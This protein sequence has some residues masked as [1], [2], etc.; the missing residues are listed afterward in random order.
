MSIIKTEHAPTH[1]L[2][3][4]DNLVRFSHSQSIFF[5]LFLLLPLS[6][7]CIYA[8][9]REK[10]SPEKDFFV[11]LKRSCLYASEQCMYIRREEE[12][13][14]VHAFV[15][16]CDNTTSRS[17]KTRASAKERGRKSLVLM[18]ARMGCMM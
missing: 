12:E 3:N 11:L 6:L 8:R 13:K 1:K 9:E 2:R 7:I 15:R 4:I 10:K 17:K 18:D 5:S 16:E 14:K